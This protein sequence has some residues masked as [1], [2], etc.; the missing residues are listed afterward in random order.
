M[1]KTKLKGSIP[2]F[3][4]YETV[5][6][7]D[8]SG[9]K[10]KG[11]IW[12]R[13]RDGTY[14]VRILKTGKM[15]DRIP[16]KNLTG[17]LIGKSIEMDSLIGRHIG[18]IYLFNVPGFA[19]EASRWFKVGKSDVDMHE[20]LKSYTT[21][22]PWDFHVWGLILFEERPTNLKRY[23]KIQA[24]EGKILNKY[25]ALG[26]TVMRYKYQKTSEWIKL[27]TD[28]DIAEMKE[29]MGKAAKDTGGKLTWFPDGH[30]I[31]F[32]KGSISAPEVIPR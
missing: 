8:K 14:K 28:P 17:N 2:R 13:H 5:I 24:A 32:P 23:E 12:S 22:Y 21:A 29:T 25:R 10:E 19:G 30:V 7:F 3:P 6:I 16:E 27:L 4:L 1:H 11:E 20:R 9:H 31:Q 18:G 15:R 26:K